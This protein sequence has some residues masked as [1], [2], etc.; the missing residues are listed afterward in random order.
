MKKFISA[1]TGKMAEF[2]PW[3][4]LVFISLAFW[5]SHL[6]LRFLLLFRNNPYGFPFVSK[7]DW[8]IFHAICLDF[9]WI[10]KALLVFALFT[11]LFGY[12]Q[13]KI[14]KKLSQNKHRVC[15]VLYT[16]FHSAILLTTLLDNE[17]QR[18]WEATFPLD[19]Q[20][21]TRTLRPL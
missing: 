3:K 19:L 10:G 18:F 21:L 20:T 8:Y 11:V 1:V 4:N 12:I 9:L 17:V 5:G 15:T 16:I 7:P 2:A 14:L 13:S 6:L